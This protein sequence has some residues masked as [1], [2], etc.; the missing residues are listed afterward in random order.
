M[1][2]NRPVEAASALET[3]PGYIQLSEGTVPDFLADLPEVRTRLGGSAAQ[4]RVKEVGDGNLNL[5]YQVEGPEGACCVKQALPYVRLVG[6]DWPMPLNRAFFEYTCLTEHGRY[7]GP[8]VPQIHHYDPERYAIVMEWLRPHIIM[9]RGMIDG[10]VYRRFAKDMGKYCA[11]TLFH[12][13]TL[14][15]PAREVKAQMAVFAGNTELCKI[16]EDLIFTDPYRYNPRNRWTSPQLDD[17]KAAFEAD[18][19]LKTGISRLKAKFMGAPEA[20]IHGD[21]HTGSIMVTEDDTKVIDS[22]FAFYGP[23]GFDL[24]AIIGNLLINYLAQDGHAAEK[25]PSRTPRAD[26]QRWVLDTIEK[27]WTVF[28][29]WF[30]H[31][32]ETRGTGDAYPADLFA[33]PAGADRLDRER[34]RYLQA[35]YIDALGFAGAKMIRR[36]LGLA[37][38]IDLEWI[39]NP[40]LRAACERRCL[41]LARDLVVNTQSYR[42]I[43]HVIES[44]ERRRHD[45]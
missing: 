27:F 22:E 43:S 4:W 32:W 20:L 30:T 10:I 19:D 25:R 45:T 6:P 38:N 41:A 28:E 14:H 39:E 36:I 21:L 35:L 44:A 16:T 8:A 40:D 37:H 26:Y 12:T 15:R 3:P 5:V 18:V 24:G 13:S 33:D 1:S 23:S 2:T 42:T 29:L 34:S 11:R 7:A 17:A 9:R 31:L